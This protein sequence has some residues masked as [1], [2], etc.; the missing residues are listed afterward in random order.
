MADVKW[1]CLSD[2]H[3]GA[4]TA[5]LSDTPAVGD[6]LPAQPAQ[7][8][9]DALC[10]GLTATIKALAPQQPPSIVLL[11]DIMDLSLGTPSAAADDLRAF[12]KSLKE[13]LGSRPLGPFLF[14][15]GNHDHELWTTARFQSFA[16]TGTASGGFEHV[17]P[18]FGATSALAAA[19]AIDKIAR[20]CGFAGA[21]TAYPNAGLWNAAKN[22]VVAL[23][24]GHF[25]ETMYRAMSE[26]ISALGTRPDSEISARQ[27]ET[28]NGSWID[29]L[30]STD[31]DDGMLGRDIFLGY[32]YLLTGSEETPF[33]H[34]LARVLHERMM[35]SLPIMKTYAMREA[36]GLVSRALVDAT[37]GQYGQLERFSY[38][39]A[40]GAA[41]VEG[42]RRYLAGPVLKQIGAELTG[43][44]DADLT[45]IFGHTHKPFE[46]RLAA[47]PFRRP[48]AVYN[49]GGW[50]LDT[51][52]FGTRI[53]A[54]AVLVDSDLNVA[55]LRLSDVPRVD[56][57]TPPPGGAPNAR[58]ET[59]D[60]VIAGN[61]LAAALDTALKGPIEKP[62]AAFAGLA[63]AAWR[64]KQAYI[65]AYLRRRDAERRKDGNVL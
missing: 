34:R 58:V 8:L 64:A 20:D 14:V 26:L 18:A 22:R 30:W 39:Q 57:P 17:T 52:M 48:P 27:L 2:L 24:H 4:P 7:P 45:F 50:N 12:L 44:A 11:G 31:G 37:V 3:L 5:L 63:D 47:A 6:A 15:P 43:A 55:S 32:E 60:G 54:A 46:D 25:V 1:I 13:R 36:T 62:W 59:A 10:L 65:L 28:E 33:N 49:T 41:T 23:H 40:M 19:P 61:P 51:P 35:A 9:R 38:A 29:F 21:V 53:G 56:G 16:A 42:L